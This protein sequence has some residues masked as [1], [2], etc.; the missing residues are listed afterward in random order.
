MSDRLID[1]QLEMIQAQFSRHPLLTSC[2]RAFTRYQANMQPLLFAPEEVFCESAIIIDQIMKLPQTNE[3]KEYI[4][5]LW[6]KLRI[7]YSKWEKKATP[8]NLDMAVSSVLYTVAIAMNRHW[9]TFYYVDVTQWLLQ[10]IQQGMEVDYHDMVCVFSD[11]LDDG[12]DIE[13]WINNNYSGHLNDEIVAVIK[14]KQLFSS[15]V[16]NPSKASD[17][18]TRL[19]QLMEGKKKPKDVMMPIRAAMDAGAIRRPTEEEFNQEFGQRR[20]KAKSS[21]N[22]YTNPDRNPYSGSDFD[23]MKSEFKKIIEE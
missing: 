8:K 11:L 23:T 6:N 14:G 7:K 21:F 15:A 18:I 1:D 3:V 20:V 10:A 2:H 16:I 22:D 12:D 4:A 13:D 17:I 5:E 19:H 9:T